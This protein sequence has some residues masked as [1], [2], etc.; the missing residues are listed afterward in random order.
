MGKKIRGD[1]SARSRCNPAFSKTF[2][3][4]SGVE[5]VRRIGCWIEEEKLTQTRM[6]AGFQLSYD[7]EKIRE[8]SYE[9]AK[10]V[11]EEGLYT[12]L[13][14]N[15]NVQKRRLVPGMSDESFL[16]VVE[17]EKTVPMTKEE[18]RALS[19]PVHSPQHQQGDKDTGD[20]SINA[21]DPFGCDT[22]ARMHF[23]MCRSAGFGSKHL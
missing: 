11:K 2:L 14:C 21:P 7:R 15:E 3:L 5:D 17:G 10:N 22:D 16:R 20:T 9:E 23:V 13:L 6:I 8:L 4:V 1:Q 18:E 12:L 19:L